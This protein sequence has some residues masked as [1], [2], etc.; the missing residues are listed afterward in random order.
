[1]PIEKM[2]VSVDT[3]KKDLTNQTD[4]P[5]PFRRP[6]NRYNLYFILERERLIQMRGGHTTR[7]HETSL[8]D[9]YFR[10]ELPPFPPRYRN[11][12]IPENWYFP[13]KKNQKR[14]HRRTHGVASFCELARIIAA[15]WKNIDDDTLSYLA[16]VETIL[17]RRHSEIIENDKTGEKS[18]LSMSNTIR[19]P[20]CLSLPN[21]TFQSDERNKETS[22]IPIR[23]SHSIDHVRALK[24]SMKAILSRVWNSLIIA[25][26]ATPLQAMIS[27]GGS[28]R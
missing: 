10:V 1:M 27:S 7:R 14:L 6:Y 2:T 17:K 5:R 28:S 15:S 3:T 16:T 13:V 23:A 20:R 4:A 18:S 8:A 12:F 24:F 25:V 26:N 9:S 22:V 21:I 11:I 19:A